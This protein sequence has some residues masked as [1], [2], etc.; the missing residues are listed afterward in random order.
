MKQRI[1]VTGFGVKV[2]N[3]EN[4][5]ELLQNL[6]S[7]DYKF[8]V[9][10]DL[11]PDGAALTVGEVKQP[12]GLLDDKQYRVLP[13]IAKLAI[14][15]L[16]EALEMS[17]LDLKDPE[18][19]TGIF[20]GTTMGGTTELEE[21]VR[22]SSG[23]LFKEMPIYCCGLV[24]YHSLASA[25]AG[26]FQLDGITKTVTTGCTA[27]IEA[28]EDAMMYLQNG[29]INTAIVGAADSSSNKVTVFGFGKLRA[30]PFN[31]RVEAA[32]AP[33]SKKSKG[34]I[35]SEGAAGLIL[36]TEEHA[37]ARKAVIYGYIDAIAT[38]NDSKSVNGYDPAGIKMKQAVSRVLGGRIPDYY[39]SQALGYAPNDSIEDIV[40]RDVFQHKVRLT[41]IKG[42]IG[43]P[44][45]VSGPAQI[46]ASLLG[47]REQF[48]P[49]TIRTDQSGYEHLPL[50][51]E[52]LLQPS[53][54]VLIT[55]HGYGG[56]NA[57]M[58]LTRT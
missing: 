31:Q 15:T 55:S 4:C 54:K 35:L 29:R 14:S 51:T 50:I 40:S 20:M 36:E 52:T 49:R 37:K 39:N 11:T 26:Y 12:L 13:R 42:L 16:T 33:F 3:G 10:K 18:T 45:S 27:G 19:S 46:I 2:P 8:T 25:V 6:L 17:Q 57:S 43:H 44:F 53:A 22:L 7:G 28:I 47:F 9:R 58:Y 41:S 5:D 38:N 30:L 48:I 34:F 56:N 32:G 24:H 21:M 1:A 23:D